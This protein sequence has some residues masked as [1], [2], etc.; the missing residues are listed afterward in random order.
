MKKKPI[1]SEKPQSSPKSPPS[2]SNRKNEFVAFV[3]LAKKLI[4][5]PKKD[6]PPKTSKAKS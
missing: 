1:Q 2:K 6:L 5:F 3:A 4:M